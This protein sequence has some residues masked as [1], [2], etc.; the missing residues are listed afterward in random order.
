MYNRNHQQHGSN[1]L[2]WNNFRIVFVV[3]I[4]LPTLIH[5]KT[6]LSSSIKKIPT[7]HGLDANLYLKE[8]G[9]AVVTKR[10]HWKKY[11]TLPSSSGRKTEPVGAEVSVTTSFQENTSCVTKSI[12]D[13]TSYMLGKNAEVAAKPATAPP[14]QEEGLSTAAIVYMSLLALQFGIQ[15]ILVRKFTPQTI[16]RSS[17]VLVQEVM[18]FGIAGA[19]YFS[20]TR[21]SAREKDFEGWNVKT[22]IALAALPAFLYTI[23]NVAT[24]M[25]QQNIEALTFN[26]LN[27]TKILSA[28]LSCYFILGKQ[29]SKMQ[30]LSLCLLILSTL[31]IERIVNPASLFLLSSGGSAFG[32]GK[33]LKGVSG[34]FASLRSGD[35]GRRF[36]HGVVPLL[37]ASMISGTA[38]ALTQLSTQGG[39]RKVWGK[40][41][42]AQQVSRPPRNAYLFSMELS[43]ASVALLLFS[44]GCSSNGRAIL[45]SRSFFDN[46]TPHTFIPVITNSI[47]GILV[48]LVTKHAGSVRKGFALIFGL[49]LSGLFQANGT[50]VRTEQIVG[51]LLAAASLWM[52]TVHPYKAPPSNKSD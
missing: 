31:V 49:L 12:E 5:G 7:H 51:G 22:W 24:L 43:V 47:G 13:A 27:Q 38:G 29:Q 19:I 9:G 46:W 40:S 2:F 25:A 3:A 4:S 50:G 18:K 37:V 52:H 30:V 34:A 44:L 8:R 16:V 11:P 35:A 28:A 10:R 39:A 1:G 20:G 36:T 26:V 33:A 41:K 17:V 45:Q 32:I 42:S 14:K 48:G 21:K 15:P 23:Q 6:P